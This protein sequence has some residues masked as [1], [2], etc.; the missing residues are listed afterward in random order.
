[1]K[2]WTP[3]LN[4]ILK[5]LQWLII[6]AWLILVWD[7]LNIRTLCVHCSYCQKLELAV[8]CVSWH[9]CGDFLASCSMDNTAKVWDLNSA[10]S[11]YTLRGHTDSVNSI[12]FLPFSNTILTC[13]A[14]KTLSL[15]DARTVSCLVIPAERCWGGYC[16]GVVSPSVT[17]FCLDACLGNGLSDFI[18]PCR[19]PLTKW[20]SCQLL[21]KIWGKHWLW[22]P[23]RSLKDWLPLKW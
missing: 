5:K 2:L 10:R 8:W 15:W 23:G 12:E 17:L 9:S 3:F 4:K 16:F 14:D 7:G 13:S 21:A 20:E 19:L 1:M 6:I 22:H 11:R 18:F